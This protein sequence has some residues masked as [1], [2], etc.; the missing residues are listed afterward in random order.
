[1]VFK[2]VDIAFL[3]LP[4]G[5]TFSFHR[6]GT[7]EVVVVVIQVDPR[8]LQG[9]VIF[10]LGT[11]GM[12]GMLRAWNAWDFHVFFGS[13]NGIAMRLG[14]LVVQ[15]VPVALIIAAEA[16]RAV[17]DVAISHDQI[18]RGKEQEYKDGK[19]AGSKHGV[20]GV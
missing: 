18:G 6:E 17:Q 19:I 11:L 1:M 5:T 9:R 12:L 2:V 3:K 14:V 13:W 16:H 7:I 4:V 8:G 10:G 20:D 15:W